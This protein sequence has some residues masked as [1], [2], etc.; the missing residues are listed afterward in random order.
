M[1]KKFNICLLIALVLGVAYVVYGL[2]YFTG[3]ISSSTSDS[4]AVGSAIA[5]VIVMPHLACTFIAVI[6]NGL[7]VFL[8]RRGFALT[9][10][11]LY[12]VALALF[13]IYFMFVIVQMILSYVGYSQLKKQAKQ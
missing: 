10:A 7:G 13:P 8:K 3:A 9:G 5:G 11:I 4:E 2:T 1:K 12:T 6:F